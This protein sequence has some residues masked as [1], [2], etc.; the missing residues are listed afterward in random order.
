VRLALHEYAAARKA[1]AHKS[2]M[3]QAQ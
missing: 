2:A 3:E 1:E